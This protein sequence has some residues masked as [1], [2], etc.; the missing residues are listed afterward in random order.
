MT[1][2]VFTPSCPLH[3][4]NKIALMLI[5]VYHVILYRVKRSM[6]EEVLLPTKRNFCDCC[7]NIGHFLYDVERVKHFVN[8]HLHCQ[9]PEKDKQNV[10]VAHT[11]KISVDAHGCI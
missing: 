9:Q 4:C 8:V 7:R 1:T 5:T 3:I 11:E 2:F 10:D 6:R